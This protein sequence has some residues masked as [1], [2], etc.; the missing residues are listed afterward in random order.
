MCYLAKMHK[1]LYYLLFKGYNKI[2]FSNTETKIIKT[3]DI[4]ISINANILPFE[5][6]SLVCM[7]IPQQTLMYFHMYQKTTFPLLSIV[8]VNA[9]L[10]YMYVHSRSTRRETLVQRNA[11]TLNVLFTKRVK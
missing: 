6:S 11:T 9:K 7:F 2:S 3:W 4:D 1:L 8:K 10:Y 5:Q